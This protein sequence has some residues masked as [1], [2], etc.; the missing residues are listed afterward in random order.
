MPQNA[1]YFQQKKSVSQSTRIALKRIE[2]QKKKKKKKKKHLPL[3][4]GMSNQSDLSS[5]IP[6]KFDKNPTHSIQDISRKSGTDTHTDRHTD[7][8][9]K[10]VGATVYQTVTIKFVQGNS[11][12]LQYK[13][14]VYCTLVKITTIAGFI[15]LEII[16]DNF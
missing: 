2:M 7:R 9:I 3:M 16:I 4:S 11:H 8:H 15:L 10:L 6:T 1:Q 13:G 14:P 12:F 5:K